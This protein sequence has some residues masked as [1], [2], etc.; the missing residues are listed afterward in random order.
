MTMTKMTTII[1]FCVFLHLR[2]FEITHRKFPT[3]PDPNPNSNPT[4]PLR[5]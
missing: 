4:T 1:V 5:L 3:Y 2:D